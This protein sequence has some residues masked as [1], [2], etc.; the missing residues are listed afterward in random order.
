M[1][2][3][4]RRQSRPG[5]RWFYSA[6]GGSVIV[7]AFLLAL[8]NRRGGEARGAD[9]SSTISQDAGDQAVWEDFGAGDDLPNDRFALFIGINKYPVLNADLDGCVEDARHLRQ[10]FI[11]RFKFN[12][13]RTALLTNEK[14]TRKGIH[15]A[16]KS[17]IDRVKKARAAMAVVNGK[18]PT[19]SVVIAYAGHGSRVKRLPGDSWGDGM[20]S[21]WV[22]S[23]SDRQGT[24]DVRGAELFKVHSE[25]HDL[26]AQ[27]ILISDSCHSGTIYRDVPAFKK[28][29]A[30]H[31]KD[32]AG[33]K[34][35]LF[36]DFPGTRDV[37]MNPE[38]PLP[39]FV[40]YS[41]CLDTEVSWEGRDEAD[42]PCG[43]LSLVLRQVLSHCESDISY[44]TLAA[45]IAAEFTAHWPDGGQHPQFHCAVGK[46]EEKFLDGGFDPLHAT[47]LNTAADGTLELNMGLLQGVTSSGGFIFYAS[48]DDLTAGK[49]EIARGDVVKVDAATCQVK[50]RD[51]K[52]VRADAWAALDMVRM[53][54]FVVWADQTAPGPVNDL[55]KQMAD[56]RQI[57]LAGKDASYTVAVHYDDKAQQIGLY[58]PTALP[59]PEDG[60]RAAASRGAEAPPKGRVISY[61]GPQDLNSVAE[62]L[63]YLARVHRLLSLDHTGPSIT[64]SLRPDGARGVASAETPRGSNGIVVLKDRESYSLK[65]SSSD[66][67]EM[68][69]TMLLVKQDGTLEV[70]YPLNGDVPFPVKIGS[71]LIIPGFTAEI[72]RKDLQPGQAERTTIKILATAEPTDLSAWITAPR[73]GRPGKQLAGD[74]KNQGAQPRGSGTGFYELMGDVMHGGELAQDPRARNRGAGRTVSTPWSAAT[75]V[76]DVEVPRK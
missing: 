40:S 5:N 71:P 30:P 37:N 58:D 43:R 51:G 62:N 72:E 75:I 54:P 10:L 64:A 14:A 55:L 16:L 60:N 31:D 48:E 23:D 28:R 4:R 61:R 65:V 24:N 47:I 67:R 73:A 20:D 45:R 53:D 13:K 69:T 57:K 25:L 66:S 59:A 39:G 17:L 7:I 56:A 21:T 76:Y 35:D 50:V 44:Q 6:I 11:D 18:L 32:A 29:Q 19:I 15:A 49:N 38:Q 33:P 42:K 2:N 63:L 46:A 1:R 70:L 3:N 41:G 9:G 68:Y 26:G 12:P 52:T 36:S 74:V 22:A 34:D 8:C 27:V